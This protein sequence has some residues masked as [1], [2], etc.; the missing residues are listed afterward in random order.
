MGE[1]AS[2]GL[3][4]Q[5]ICLYA[6]HFHCISFSHVCNGNPVAHNFA[7]HA[8]HVAD[9]LVWM[10]DVPLQVSPFYLADLASVSY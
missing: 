2:F 6:E 5:D 4:I 9:S 3:L 7:R 8:R 10:E 1:G